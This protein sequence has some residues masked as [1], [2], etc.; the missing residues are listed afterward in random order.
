MIPPRSS[1][2]LASLDAWTPEQRKKL[3]ES[4]DDSDYSLGDW[5]SALGVFDA[6]MRETGEAR[7]PWAEMAGYIHCCTFLSSPGVALGKLEVIVYKSL[8]EFGFDFVN[9]SQT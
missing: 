4:V 9:E 1:F 2:T 6:W 5:I 8:T 3:Y 7:R